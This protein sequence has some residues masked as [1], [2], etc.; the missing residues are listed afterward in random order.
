[1]E[2]MPGGSVYPWPMSSWPVIALII[3]DRIGDLHI[4]RASDKKL[5]T[6]LQGILAQ[7]QRLDSP[8][9]GCRKT[10]SARSKL[11]HGIGS[12]RQ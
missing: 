8:D 7:G 12:G 1:M 9:A 4:A 10:L 2:A 6:F 11:H 3:L 5:E